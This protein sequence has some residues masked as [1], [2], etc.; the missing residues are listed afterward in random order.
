ML[1]DIREWISDNLRYIL[2]GAACLLLLLIL[3]FAVRLITKRGSGQEKPAKQQQEEATEPETQSV[4]TPITTNGDALERNQDQETLAEI[5][6]T[7]D[8]A[9]NGSG[10]ALDNAIEQYN[11]L[12]TYSKAGLTEGSYV[13]F[14]YFDAKLTGIDTLVPTLRGLYLVTN[15]EGK[16]IVSNPKNHPDQSAYQ[17]QVWTDDDVQALRKDVADKYDDSLTRDPDLAAFVES[18]KPDAGN[19]GGDTAGGETGDGADAGDT[20]NTGNA[21]VGLGT[22]YASTGVNV[23]SEPNAE[24][25]KYGTLDTGMQVEVLENLDNGWSRVSYISTDGTT[26]EGYMMTQYLTD[27]Q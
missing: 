9:A 24:S 1:N 19:S 6:E 23:R 17:E 3:I 2:L 16:L 7:A 20:D 5:C 25:T 27:A 8:D 13:A 26:V 21:D 14:A 11:N 12:M 18:L 15:D 4:D 10:D 22:M